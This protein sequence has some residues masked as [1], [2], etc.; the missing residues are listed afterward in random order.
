MKNIIHPLLLL[1]A[2]TS[3]VTG[4]GQVFIGNDDFSAP[5][6]YRYNPLDASA[7]LPPVVPGQWEGHF[8]Q[9]EGF[10]HADFFAQDGRFHFTTS[11]ATDYMYY[12]TR[13]GTI[14]SARSPGNA[15]LASGSPYNTSWVA[16]FDLFNTSTTETKS[17]LEIYTGNGEWSHGIYLTTSSTGNKIV[18]LSGDPDGIAFS[19]GH[20]IGSETSATARAEFDANT[21]LLSFSYSVGGSAFIPLES[22]GITLPDIGDFHSERGLGIAVGVYTESSLSLGQISF[23]NLN[24][25]AVPEPSTY[26]AIAGLGAIGFAAWRRRTR[27][28]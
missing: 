5:I 20:S 16:T 26:A 1:S 17:G 25:T 21:K 22:Y 23:D 27:A 7:P 10:E 11:Q 8:G 2:L 15:G 4:V 18:T 6:V 19:P 12:A 28:A 3:A 9:F 24:I 13:I 14:E